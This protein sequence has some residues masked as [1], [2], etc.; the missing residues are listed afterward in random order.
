MDG[1]GAQLM[2][3]CSDYLVP[4]GRP[5][6]AQVCEPCELT[7]PPPPYHDVW[8]SDVVIDG[9]AGKLKRRSRTSSQIFDACVGYSLASRMNTVVVVCVK[10]KNGCR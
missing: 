9:A 10:R 5:S 6:S 2:P 8:C 7:P 1:N 3:V 4:V